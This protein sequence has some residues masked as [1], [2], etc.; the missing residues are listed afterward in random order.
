M[1]G[2]K[3]KLQTKVAGSTILEVVVA[4]V[5]IIIVFSTAM[6]IYANVIKLSLSTKKLRAQAILQELLLQAAQTKNN[7]EQSSQV[8][9]FR[10]EQ[11]IKPLENESEL[12]EIRLT[13]FDNNQEQVA[14]AQQVIINESN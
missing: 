13:A 12:C 2:N 11:Q 1:A 4:M 10:I 14:Q 3:I 9:E 8:G 7:R 6:V 5:I